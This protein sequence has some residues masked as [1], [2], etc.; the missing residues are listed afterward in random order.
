MLINY[1]FLQ[2]LKNVYIT[3]SYP[4]W[5]LLESLVKGKGIGKVSDNKHWTMFHAIDATTPKSWA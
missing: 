5:N 1:Y 3:L 4:I 2:F